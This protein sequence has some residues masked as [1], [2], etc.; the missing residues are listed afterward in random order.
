MGQYIIGALMITY[1]ILGFP[2]YGEKYNA[3]QNPVLIIKAPT[4]SGP[5]ML[6]G[7]ISE[8]GEWEVIYSTF[9]TL[10]PKPQTLN[11]F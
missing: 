8:P 7:A 2:Y 11:V 5:A 1:T 10:N 9:L 3:P 6:R 4:A